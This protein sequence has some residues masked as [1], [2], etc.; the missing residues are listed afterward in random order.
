MEDNYN[1]DETEQEGGNDGF[2]DIFPI[3]APPAF[4]H[5]T[6]NDKVES[7]G[8]NFAVHSYDIM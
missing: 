3:K 5:S 6:D 4:L 2:F 8:N 1:F 7:K